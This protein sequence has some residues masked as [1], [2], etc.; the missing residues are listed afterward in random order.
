MNLFSFEYPELKNIDAYENLYD[1]LKKACKF[2]IKFLEKVYKKFDYAYIHFKETDLPGHDN[3]PLEKKKMIEYLDKN[4]FLFLRKFC[5]QNGINVVVT[6][7]HSTPCNLKSHSADPVP[8]LFYNH[9]PP[10][11]KRFT[12]TEAKAGK[13]GKFEGRDLLEKVG[14]V[15]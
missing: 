5:P 15:R 2:N 1:G 6:G 7:D 3:K 13:L 4:F 14:F 10:K 12:E 9:S 11:E 8:V